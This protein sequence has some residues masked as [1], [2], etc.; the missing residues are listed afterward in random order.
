MV[1]ENHEVAIPLGP[2]SRDLFTNPWTW[3]WE[4]SDD[5]HSFSPLVGAHLVP[6]RGLVF[7]ISAGWWGTTVV[8]QLYFRAKVGFVSYD[9]KPIK[10]AK[11]MAQVWAQDSPSSTDI[12]AGD[13]SVAI[14]LD[15]SGTE[16]PFYKF[17]NV[18]LTDSAGKITAA[19]A[20][21][22]SGKL[23]T[24]FNLSAVAPGNATIRVQ[25]DGQT[26]QD[27]PVTVF[28]APKHPSI[29]IFCGKG[30]RVLRI[31]GPEAG[32]V[33]SVQV[34]ALSVEQTDNSDAAIRRLTLSGP[35][36]STV[37]SVAVTYKDPQRGLEW[38]LP[39]PVSVGLARPRVAAVVV[40]QVPSSVAIGAG[41][42]ATWAMATLPPG[43]FRSNQP[44]RVQL[45]ADAPFAW[46]H[47]VALDLGFGSAGDVQKVL[48]VPE[49]P[50][51]S[52]DELSPNAYLTLDVAATLP[53]D[54]KRNSGL[55]WVQLTRGD[56]SSP[57]TLVN[58]TTDNVPVPLKAVKVPVI[59]SITTTAT[60]VHLTLSNCDQ[61]LAVK[62][63]GVAGPISPQFIDSNATTT[64]PVAGCCR[65]DN[66]THSLPA[67]DSPQ[68]WIF[69]RTRPSLISNSETQ[70][71]ASSTSKS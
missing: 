5:G 45:N 32:W 3:Q 7:P 57:W 62:V 66:G 67:Q 53:K 65:D 12:A 22:Y 4:A 55:V 60:G 28:I 69:P 13:P 14:H 30:D 71:T 19:T 51:F 21:T 49:G 11:I 25:Q 44:I 1:A 23:D 43:W 61:L 70:T 56:L 16:Q 27:P 31:S 42:D 20:V 10:I 54:T 59:Q 24:Q 63:A 26:G 29:S 35:L 48:T 9:T 18:T 47:D 15:R 34:T 40:G 33:K 2:E 6:G 58:A 39:E 64:P 36:P 52:M 38:T 8:K 68:R 37:H 41:A 46:T 50:I 17:F